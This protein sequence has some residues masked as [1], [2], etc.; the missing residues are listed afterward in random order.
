VAIQ[1]P[2]IQPLTDPDLKYSTL[3]NGQRVSAREK[4]IA[5]FLHTHNVKY[6]YEKPIVLEG[7]KIKP[8]FYLPVFDLDIQFWSMLDKPDYFQNFK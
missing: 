3:K 7:Q 8:Y 1:A 2:T 6:V 4:Y 5:D